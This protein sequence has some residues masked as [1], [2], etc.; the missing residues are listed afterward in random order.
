M[1]KRLVLSL[2]VLIC[3][4][5]AHAQDCATL[6]LVD[7]HVWTENPAQ[8]QAEAIAVYGNRILRVGTSDE[9]RRLAGPST[10]VIDLHGRRVVP[11]FN[12]AHVHFV[13]GGLV[14]ANVQ[15]L[16]VSSQAEFASVLAALRS[17]SLRA[18]GSFPAFGITSAGR[19]PRSQSIS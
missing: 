9:V 16:D 1:V 13:T 11:G 17:R 6:V 2:A 3:A 5:A 12:D 19:L 7:G 15:L 10:R 8:P 4:A 18:H 14:L